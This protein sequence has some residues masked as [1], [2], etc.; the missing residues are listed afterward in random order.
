MAMLW[1]I[2]EKISFIMELII[3]LMRIS[4]ALIWI[5]KCQDAWETI[6]HK[7]MEAPMLII[8]HWDKEFHVHINVSNLAIGAMLAQNINRSYLHFHF[9]NVKTSCIDNV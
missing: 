4:K 2:V 8:L 5:H 9:D 1:K 7:Y 6:K 3:K